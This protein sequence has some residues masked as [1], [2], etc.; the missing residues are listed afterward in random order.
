[1]RNILT[2]AG[3]DLRSSFV[4]PLAYIVMT[5]FV[6]ASG[7]FFFL[8]LKYF[9]SAIEQARMFQNVAPSLNE[10]VVEPY[11]QTL[12]VVLVFMV[13]LLTMRSLAEE[14]QRGTYELLA[15]S[16]VSAAELVLGKYLGIVG[17]VTVALL[18]SFV[19]PLV[20]IIFSDPEIQ[21][22]Y[23][24]FLGLLLFALSFAAIGLS[25]SALTS[26]QT[27]A[28]FL[29]MVLFLILFVIDAPA[30][31]LEGAMADFLKYVSPT[32]RVEILL[33]G[34]L[35][36][37]SLVYFGSMILLGLFMTTRVLEYQRQRG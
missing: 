6:L 4:T 37:G 22:I 2:I 13:P 29:G 5:G 7:F 33:K 20:L 19:F 12:L 35:E 27:V 16:P 14:K 34:V 3:K 26:S 17:V 23:I 30:G 28:G 32:N 15:T 25:L 36:G 8:L 1:M 21:P 11:Y 24:G 31:K 10:L 18:L 9:N